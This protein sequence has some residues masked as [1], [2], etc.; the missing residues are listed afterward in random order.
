MFDVVAVEEFLAACIA[1][2]PKNLRISTSGSRLERVTDRR[3][4]NA[5]DGW[6]VG[7]GVVVDFEDTLLR[8]GYLSDDETRYKIVT[9]DG[10]E[11]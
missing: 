5:W 8:S 3:S 6:L 1:F 11:D 7:V 2:A 10:G 4:L 9:E